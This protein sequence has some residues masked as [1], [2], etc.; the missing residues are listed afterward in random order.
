LWIQNVGVRASDVPSRLRDRAAPVTA[1][2]PDTPGWSWV[3][4]DGYLEADELDALVVDLAAEAGQALAFSV[5]DSDS[6]YVVGATAGDRFRLVV[7]PDSYNGGAPPQELDAAAAFAGVDVAPLREALEP[8]YVFAEQGVWV[9][10]ARMGLVPEGAPPETIDVDDPDDEEPEEDDGWDG[11]HV[12]SLDE[13]GE[14][15]VADAAPPLPGSRWAAEVSGL[16]GQDDRRWLVVAAEFPEEWINFTGLHPA[17]F[18]PAI[19][20]LYAAIPAGFGLQLRIWFSDGERCYEAAAKASS[21]GELREMITGPGCNQELGA[22]VAVPEDVLGSLS[23]TI[24]WAV[25]AVFRNH[26]DRRTP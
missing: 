13:W 15:V 5:H 25:R 20:D 26:R 12:A 19:R 21:L 7:N 24:A 8:D 9:V 1:W 3:S 23:D 6:A 17:D 10:L 11:D 22:W 16:A 2:L 4:L 18:P 14:P